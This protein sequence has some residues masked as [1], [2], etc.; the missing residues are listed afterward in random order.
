MKKY[1]LI[2]FLFSIVGI[3]MISSGLLLAD[4]NRIA[5]LNSISVEEFNIK[6]LATSANGAVKDSNDGN[7]YDE[8]LLSEIDMNTA[9]SGV[10]RV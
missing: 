4:T 10:Y 6:N 9:E 8:L 5:G 7:K 2:S 1:K 3:L